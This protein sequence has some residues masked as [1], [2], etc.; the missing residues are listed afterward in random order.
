MKQGWG[1]PRGEIYAAG[2]GAW[3]LGAG[4]KTSGRSKGPSGQ[5]RRGLRPDPT[6]SL[7]QVTPGLGVV[8]VVLLLLV[9][10]E[11]P[12]GA[13]ER[14]GPPSPLHYTSWCDDVRALARK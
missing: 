9:M 1:S 8:A 4:P 3:V 13:V 10:K 14:H 5:G 6:P 7:P 12:R 11:P 2:G